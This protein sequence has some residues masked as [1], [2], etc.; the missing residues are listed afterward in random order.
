MATAAA[1][2]IVTTTTTSNGDSDRQHL[3]HTSDTPRTH[4]DTRRHLGD[5]LVNKVT[6][7]TEAA[8]VHGFASRLR[9]ILS[10]LGL[11]HVPVRPV[12]A[13]AG[14]SPRGFSRSRSSSTPLRSER[15]RM[16]A[17]T[18]R[19][20]ATSASLD[21]ALPARGAGDG[22][23]AAAPEAAEEESLEPVG[24]VLL[25]LYHTAPPAGITLVSVASLASVAQFAERHTTLFRERTSRIV[26][27]A[28]TTG[29]GAGAGVV[30]ARH[31]LGAQRRV[32]WTLARPISDPSRRRASSSSR[33]RRRRR[34]RRARTPSWR[35]RR[36]RACMA[37]T[38]RRHAVAPPPLP[39]RRSWPLLRPTC[40]PSPART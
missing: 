15:W 36:V 33:R 2:A 17:A 27:M 20:V 31:V 30:S 37:A 13:A 4:L 21:A 23:S 18:A 14:R 8:A 11:S 40:P 26:H 39:Q 6:T 10:A 28:D 1:V 22:G 34:R 35:R 9:Q 24:K 29:R 3:G 38:P 5:P 7:A 32:S 19:G 25:R 16:L 12:D